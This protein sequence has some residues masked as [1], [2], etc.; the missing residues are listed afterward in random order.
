MQNM[1]APMAQTV[2]SQGRGE[3]TMLVHMTPDEVGGLQALAMAGGGSLSINPETGLPE[4]GFLK[5]YFR[6]S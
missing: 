5:N 1:Y 2:Q 6:P 4:A 3:D